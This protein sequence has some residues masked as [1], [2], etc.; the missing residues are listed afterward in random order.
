MSKPASNAAALIRPEA[1]EGKAYARLAHPLIIANPSLKRPLLASLVAA[2]LVVVG[3]GVVPVSTSHRGLGVISAAASST[4]VRADRQ[5]QVRQI[6]NQGA[7][8]SAGSAISVIDSELKRLQTDLAE[9]TRARRVLEIDNAHAQKRLRPQFQS[10]DTGLLDKTAGHNFVVPSPTDG[11]VLAIY[12]K[13]GDWITPGDEIALVGQRPSGANKGLTIFV[14]PEVANL[15]AEKQ[16]VRVWPNGSGRGDAPLIGTVQ[17][18]EQRT[19]EGYRVHGQQPGAVPGSFVAHVALNEVQASYR[20]GLPELRA[21]SETEVEIVFG[22]RRLY[23]ALLP[24]RLAKGFAPRR[25]DA[26]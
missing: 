23:E 13:V 22:S 1:L 5:G 3:L 8:V 25:G 2:V 21:G 4:V 24:R 16:L 6:A 14:P 26:P 7:R 20:E 18:V 15:L 19:L 11:E 9:Q 17:T 10:E 12:K